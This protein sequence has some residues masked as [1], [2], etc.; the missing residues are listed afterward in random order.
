[1]LSFAN[2][3]ELQKLIF[4][5]FYQVWCWEKMDNLQKFCSRHSKIVVGILIF[6]VISESGIQFLRQ[7][8]IS[9]SKV[10]V[11]IKVVPVKNDYFLHQKFEFHK[12]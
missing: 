7:G 12:Y 10:L 1:M 4:F 2:S 5:Y 8:E 6:I 11:P 3:S 9:V